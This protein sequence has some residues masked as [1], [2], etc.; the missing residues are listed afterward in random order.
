MAVYAEFFKK[1][2]QESFAYRL[3]A[4]S[5]LLSAI[6]RMLAQVSMWA[7]LLKN[8]GAAAGLELPDMVSF[9]VINIVVAALTNASVGARI[10]EKVR[11]GTI[12]VDFVRPI[13]F[14][15]YLFADELG[16]SVYRALLNSLPVCALAAILFGFRLPASFGV[17]VA[18]IISLAM[19]VLLGY[20][21]SYLMGLSTFWLHTP[22]HVWWVYRTLSE[23]FGGTFVPLWYYPDPL[24]RLS[25]WLPFHLVA[26]QPISI[27]LGRTPIAQ[28]PGVL[29]AQF[30]WLAGLLFVERIV[31]RRAERQ[32]TVQGG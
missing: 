23:V 6:I 24:V 11:D 4:Y 18:F 17:N 32:V 27:Y 22:W 7:A 8:R 1:S 16:R 31:W 20:H 19:G 3:N 15:A 21:I 12:A 30:A 9:V 13:H 25:L 28:V 2:L 5:T 14:K 26:F 29:L 10:G